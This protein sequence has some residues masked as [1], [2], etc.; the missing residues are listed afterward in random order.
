M[1]SA[2]GSLGHSKGKI[3]RA[4]ETGS[5]IKVARSWVAVPG[6]E[7]RIVTALSMRGRVGGATALE[8][9]G[10]WV[11]STGETW[12]AVKPGTHYASA[13]SGIRIF[14]CVFTIDHT[15]PWRVSVVD[16]LA[17]YCRRVSRNEAV[18]A[19]DC[20]LQKRLLERREI[21]L[22][23]DR[24]PRRCRSWLRRVNGKAESG[25]ESILRLA[26]EDEGWSVEI[27][28]PF[29]GGRLDIVVNGWLVIEVD[30]SQFHD[31]GEQARKD[32]KRNTQLVRAGYRWHR[33]SYADVV[34]RL[35]ETIDVIRI[36]LQQGRPAL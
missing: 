26:C 28:V 3:Q 12:V 14:Q 24:L 10:I 7:R 29:R 25:L 15:A 2:L 16:A 30:G 20:A 31:V 22:L 5:L 17:Q 6:V 1:R 34:H 36:L 33:F 23:S 11:K 8:S 21:R 9:Y 4:V 19:I 13:E 32:R 35:E 18:A 27:Q